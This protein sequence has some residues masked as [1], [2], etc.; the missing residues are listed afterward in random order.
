[1]LAD[2][3]TIARFEELL[4]APP[5]ASTPASFTRFVQAELEAFAPIVRAAG[6]SPG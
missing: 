5:P 3:A 2:P 4:G 1:M 6:L